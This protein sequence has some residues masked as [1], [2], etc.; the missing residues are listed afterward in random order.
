M[1]ESS[2]PNECQYSK[3]CI[4]IISSLEEENDTRTKE[5]SDY[6][7]TI[8]EME[9]HIVQLEGAIQSKDR[10]IEKLREIMIMNGIK[11]LE[12]TV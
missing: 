7:N 4:H 10:T 1:E 9:L 2:H 5:L 12:D 3:L 11:E 8:D 6:L